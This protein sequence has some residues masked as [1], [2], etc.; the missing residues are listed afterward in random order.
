MDASLDIMS[1]FA[2]WI[3]KRNSWL[4]INRNH[5]MSRTRKVTIWHD[6]EMTAPWKPNIEISWNFRE[7]VLHCLHH[8]DAGDEPGIHNAA[9]SNLLLTAVHGAAWE[10]ADTSPP[11]L[12]FHRLKLRTF[13]MTHHWCFTKTHD[14]FK[15]IFNINSTTPQTSWKSKCT[16]LPPPHPMPTRPQEIRPLLGDDG[17]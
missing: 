14:W 10:V 9:V 1:P 17:Q 12:G 3:C 5:P 4:V 11:N 2:P 16:P 6:I 15:E 13:Q 7:P 8:G